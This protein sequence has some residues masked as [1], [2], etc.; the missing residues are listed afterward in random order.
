MALCRDWK[1]E[2]RLGLIDT[3]GNKELSEKSANEITLEDLVEK[4]RIKEA[5]KI[6]SIAHI[7]SNV[8]FDFCWLPK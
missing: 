4:P 7:V 1:E 5:Y 2:K 8:F 3:F 6:A